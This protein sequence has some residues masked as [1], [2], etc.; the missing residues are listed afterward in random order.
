MIT[1]KT[2]RRLSGYGPMSLT[3]V[4]HDSGYTKDCAIT[5]EFVGITTGGDFCYKISYRDDGEF[6]EGKVFLREDEE[7][8]IAEY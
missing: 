4:L 7:G 1:A 2:I 6:L 8:I 5:A 3:R